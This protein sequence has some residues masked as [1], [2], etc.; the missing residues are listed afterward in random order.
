MWNPWR[1]TIQ[2]SC[3]FCEPPHSALQPF[4][5]LA[6]RGNISIT[7]SWSKNGWTTWIHRLWLETRRA[8]WLP[9]RTFPSTQCAVYWFGPGS[10][11]T[12]S[13]T[14][15]IGWVCSLLCRCSR[16]MACAYSRRPSAGSWRTLVTG[17]GYFR[18]PIGWCARDVAPGRL[19]RV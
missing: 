18:R 10:G 1:Q 4:K 12:G 9:S 14:P 7:F 6:V 11:P 16:S 2:K 13:G 17:K 3:S 8:I 5:T 19:C 15:S